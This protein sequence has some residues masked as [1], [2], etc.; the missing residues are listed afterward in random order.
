MKVGLQNYSEAEYLTVEATLV[1]IFC[2]IPFCHNI[3]HSGTTIL[4]LNI[5]HG[6]EFSGTQEQPTLVFSSS[7]HEKACTYNGPKLHLC[8]DWVILSS[9]HVQSKSTWQHFQ[10]LIRLLK[11]K[12]LFQSK[13]FIW[14]SH[15]PYM[16]P[17]LPI[18]T[19]RIKY[20]TGIM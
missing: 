1:V 14:A 9:R 10:Y 5:S 20:K 3:P 7:N 4:C 16:S 11:N 17:C 2:N 18:P 6:R 8:M 19:L 15:C 13:I 12:S